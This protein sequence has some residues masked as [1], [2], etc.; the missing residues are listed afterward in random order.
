MKP[1]FDIY[2]K[3][4]TSEHGQLL[5]NLCFALMGLYITFIFS[6]HSSTV[7]SLCALVAALLQY[8]FLVTFMMMASE[9]INLY[10]K[11]VVVLGAK[12]SHFVLK[13]TVIS[14][15]KMQYYHN[16]YNII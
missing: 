10:M 16:I 7:T 9:A 14:W 5:I 12:I 6:I 15:C 13:A 11:L 1:Y 2:R 4:R 8:F 3:L